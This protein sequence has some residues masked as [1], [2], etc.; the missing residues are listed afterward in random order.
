MHVCVC[1]VKKMCVFLSYS[2]LIARDSTFIP[3]SLNC[4]WAE[5]LMPIFSHNF[6]L[7]MPKPAICCPSL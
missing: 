2:N 1:H 7:I 6:I 5:L 3:I 4:E